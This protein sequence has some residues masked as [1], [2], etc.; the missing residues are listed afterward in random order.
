MTYGFVRSLAEQASAR[1]CNAIVLH[2]V[3]VRSMASRNG[4]FDFARVGATCV[5]IDRDG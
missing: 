2:D 5:W 3:C 4:R 1:G